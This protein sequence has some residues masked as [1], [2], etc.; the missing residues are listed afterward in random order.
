[1]S[2]M[3][4]IGVSAPSRIQWLPSY[5]AKSHAGDGKQLVVEEAYDGAALDPQC[6]NAARPGGS[7]GD[8]GSEMD[9][10]RA[11]SWRCAPPRML[12]SEAHDATTSDLLARSHLK[13]ESY[14]CFA[15]KS[16]C[17]A[18]LHARLERFAP[19]RTRPSCSGALLVRLK[20][21]AGSLSSSAAICPRFYPTVSLK[22]CTGVG[23]DKKG[24][25][26]KDSKG[27]CSPEKIRLETNSV[28]K[29]DYKM[30]SVVTLLS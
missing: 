11:V 7:S 3:S 24:I 22:G 26:K 17:A 16:R 8:G 13:L 20:N 4:L 6:D 9:D 21:H 23:S 15:S 30:L 29:S 5:T 10:G 28:V 14:E 19:A 18:G 1:M 25:C 2:E 12:S 27:T